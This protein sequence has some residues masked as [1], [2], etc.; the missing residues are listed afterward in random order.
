MDLFSA[1]QLNG[2][3]WSLARQGAFLCFLVACALL[4]ASLVLPHAGLPDSSRGATAAV[5]TPP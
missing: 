2:K 1:E 4:G 3:R 5:A